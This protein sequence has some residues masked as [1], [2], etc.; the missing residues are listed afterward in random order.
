[1]IFD[2]KVDYFFTSVFASPSMGNNQTL[3]KHIEKNNTQNQI[4][5]TVQLRIL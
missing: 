5:Q 4:K 1:M 2:N 3:H